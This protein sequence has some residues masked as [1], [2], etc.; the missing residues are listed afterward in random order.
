M[1]TARTPAKPNVA[2]RRGDQAP[3]QPRAA[4]VLFAEHGWPVLPASTARQDRHVCARGRVTAELRPTL[5]IES[6]TTD[7]A[8]VRKWWSEQQPVLPS[9][10][11]ATATDATVAA[12][13]VPERF[14]G[15]LHHHVTYAESGPIAYRPDTGRLYLLVADDG[16]LAELPMSGSATV[17]REAWVAVPPTRLTWG[18]SVVWVRAPWH[19]GWRLPPALTI[20]PLIDAVTRAAAQHQIHPPSTS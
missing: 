18:R 14:N 9:V 16:E 10:V 4:A 8:T 19:V 3:R 5:A 20:A 6:A 7:T 13:S 15:L 11:V 1:T 17:R 2:G 12:I